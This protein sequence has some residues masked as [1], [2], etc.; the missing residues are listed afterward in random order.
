VRDLV[1]RVERFPEGPTKIR[2]SAFETIGGGNS[3]NA[4]VAI[5][6]LGGRVRL[7]SC[8]GDDEAGDW[9]MDGLTREGIDISAV[10]RREGATSPASSILIDAAGERQ[11]ATHRD[12]T[13]DH[14]L[15]QDTVAALLDG[16]A[17]VLA[18]SRFP[19]MGTPVLAEA[20]RLGLVAMLDGDRATALDDPVLRACTHAVFS[21]EALR[22]TAGECELDEALAIVARATDAL[23]AVT[24]GEHGV[25]WIDDGA[26]RHLPALRVETVDTL[27]AGDVFHGAATLALAEGADVAAAFRFGAA[28]AALKCANGHGRDGAPTRAALDAFLKDRR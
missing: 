15:P 16:A 7:A 28:A 1:F 14:A 10:V 11:I 2:A 5:A 6:R 25:Q 27:G 12:R 3:A 20:R 9:L 18:D 23:V 26:W 4:A 24:D 13:L 22:D 21:A 17:A 8:L 19:L